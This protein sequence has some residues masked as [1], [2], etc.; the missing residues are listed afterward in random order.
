MFAIPVQLSPRMLFG[1]PDDLAPTPNKECLKSL[2]LGLPSTTIGG[3]NEK[4]TSPRSPSAVKSPLARAMQ[5][6][7]SFFAL[8]PVVF[9][10]YVGKKS[11]GRDP[12]A[13]VSTLISRK[14]LS[15]RQPCALCARTVDVNAPL[16]LLP[17]AHI[18]HAECHEEMVLNQRMCVWCENACV[19]S[20]TSGRVLRKKRTPLEQLMYAFCCMWTW[21]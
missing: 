19:R 16:V 18:A 11:A 1:A 6:H 13:P 9:P 3:A 21:R 4:A 10:V 12:H 2:G 7:K 15:F 17:C 5:T 20:P 8:S 14:M